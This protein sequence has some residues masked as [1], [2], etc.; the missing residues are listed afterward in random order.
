[1]YFGL[2]LSRPGMGRFHYFT[3]CCLLFP[4][5]LVTE[6]G[7]FDESF[8]MYGEDV[9]LSWRLTGQRKKMVCAKNTSVQH[10]LGPSVN[11]DSFFYEYHMVR[12]HLRL[13]LRTYFRFAEV[14][15]VIVAKFSAL[16]CRAAI[17]SLRYGAITPFVAFLLALFPLRVKEVRNSSDSNTL[18]DQK[19]LPPGQ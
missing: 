6:T 11:R 15:I 9:E 12:S 14:P 5:D 13:S 18:L 8:F 2:L 16:A 3:G 17:R 4:K 7:V 19:Y 1:R 10:G